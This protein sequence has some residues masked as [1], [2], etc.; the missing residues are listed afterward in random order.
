M[1]LASCATAQTLQFGLKAGVPVTEYFDTGAAGGL[2]GAAHY[3]ATARR[4]TIA[5]S[6]EWRM[7]RALGLELDAQ[8]HRMGYVAYVSTF[9]NGNYTNSASDVIGD[10]WDFPLAAKYR[11]PRARRW[12]VLGGGVLRY[13]GPV[14]GQGQETRGPLVTGTSTTTRIDTS[15]PSELRKRFY[16]GVVL[17]VGVECP[18]AQRVKVVPEFRY[19]RWTANIAGESGLLR[20]SPNQIE[21]MLGLAF[22][23]GK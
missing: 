21:V 19:T 17:G 9:D 8:F 2:H 16:P 22:G 10:S 13:V 11:L 3:T 23:R 15:D 18:V 4:Y 20:F 14:R 7:M 1:L 5:A 6:F 12:F